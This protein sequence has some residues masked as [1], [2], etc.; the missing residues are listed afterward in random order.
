[1]G[2]SFMALTLPE[3]GPTP[4]EE[5][6]CPR[7]MISAAPSSALLGASSRLNLVSRSRHRRR[8]LPVLA[9][10]NDVV[11]EPFHAF[12]AFE[13]SQQD[14]LEPTRRRNKSL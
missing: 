5:I 4:S 10:V 7:K 1:M 14:G 11:D 9:E 13:N 2:I 8:S 6:L 12:E 3:P